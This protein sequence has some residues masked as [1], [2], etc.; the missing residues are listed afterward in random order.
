MVIDMKTQNSTHRIIENRLVLP[1]DEIARAEEFLAG[2]GTYEDENGILRASVVGCPKFDMKERIAMVHSVTST[3]PVI[4]KGDLVIG[5]IKEIKGVIAIVTL[6]AKRGVNR[7]IATGEPDAVL[8]ISK[9][10][11]TYMDDFSRAYRIG[12]VIRARVIQAKPQV[13]ITTEGPEL[14]VIS[15]TC[16]QCQVSL[17]KKGRNLLQCPIC[18]KTSMRKIALDYGYGNL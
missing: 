9:V 11:K 2:Y 12:D 3:P 8:H 5:K 13:Q 15:A 14:G 18:E 17:V 16:P 10:S 1:G 4:R 7:T 6:V